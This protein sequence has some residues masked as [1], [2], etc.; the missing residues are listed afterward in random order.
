MNDNNTIQYCCNCN[1][2]LNSKRYRYAVYCDIC[3]DDGFAFK[4][5]KN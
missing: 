5:L 4:M 1:K 2:T 3:W